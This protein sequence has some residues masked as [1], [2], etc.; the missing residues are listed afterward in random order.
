MERIYPGSDG[1]TVAIYGY[2]EAIPA[3]TAVPPPAPPS[4]IPTVSPLGVMAPGST[5]VITG[6][7][8]N[9]TFIGATAA[10]L[11]FDM[12]NAASVIGFRQFLVLTN[13]GENVIAIKESETSTVEITVPAGATHVLIDTSVVATGYVALRDYRFIPNNP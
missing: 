7:P 2:G 9:Q 13:T 6:A 12:S 1:V 11:V 10:E 5:K 3:L 8:N 4:E